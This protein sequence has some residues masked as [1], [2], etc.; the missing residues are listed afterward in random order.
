MCGHVKHLLAGIREIHPTVLETLAPPPEG[1]IEDI[2]A[3]RD[4]LGRDIVAKGNINLTFMAN[5]SPEEVY[6]AGRRIIEQAGPDRFILSVADVLLDY[7]PLENVKALVRA[8][9]DVKFQQRKE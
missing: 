3:A 5:A 1:D 9:H 6:K 4:A 2:A 8:G 7:H